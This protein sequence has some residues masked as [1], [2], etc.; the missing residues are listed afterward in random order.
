LSG[1]VALHEIHLEDQLAA[2]AFLKRLPKVDRDRVAVAGCSYGGIQ[3]ILA[4]EASAERKAHF[5]AAVDFAGAAITWRNAPALREKMITAARKAAVPV[6]FVQAENDYDLSPSY[7]LAKELERLGKPH[8]LSI[9]PSY[10]T[11]VRDGH[12]GFCNRGTAV[13][14]ADVLS[15]LAAHLRTQSEK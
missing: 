9:H 11:S 12:G 1:V 13:W 7:A 2:L 15:F 3:T 6:M 4:V 5:R 8:K 10:G 14:G